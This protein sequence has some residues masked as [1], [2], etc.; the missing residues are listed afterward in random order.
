MGTYGDYKLILIGN[1]N[2]GKT[3]F[4]NMVVRGSHIPPAPTIGANFLQLKSVINDILIKIEVWD[5]AGQERFRSLVPLYY[6][7]TDIILL[8]FDTS[9]YKTF[10]DIRDY[11]IGDINS[12]LS[13]KKCIKILVENK[14]DKESVIPKTEISNL[15]E[16]YDLIYHRISVQENT[17][18]NELLDNIFDQIGTQFDKRLK[19][20]KSSFFD[21]ENN[22]FTQG[23]LK[24]F[25]CIN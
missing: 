17:G 8:F 24:M 13:E 22:K 7:N 11:W 2:V 25:P 14:I 4:I 5:T 21:T 23:F 1:S 9:D 18:V 16:R 12:N 15:I 19:K 20:E 6:K 10:A 3:S